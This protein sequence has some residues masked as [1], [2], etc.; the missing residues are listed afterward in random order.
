MPTPEL[1]NLITFRLA[2]L[3]AELNRQSMRLL[4]RA[5]KLN[6]PEWRVISIV[7]A[8]GELNG[9][10]I[11]RLAGLDPG[12]LSRTLAAL[13]SRGL[14]LTS[15]KQDD[16]RAVWVRLSE[17]GARLE[18]AVRPVMR[19]RH[20]RLM[21]ALSPDERAAIFPILDNL[22]KAIAAENALSGEEDPDTE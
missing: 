5:G 18:A 17:E 7:Y 16:R 14:V 8:G 15:R 21:A 13:E 12:L 19:A 1:E 4:R 6:I 10:Q 20:E 11:G 3:V 2:H 22:Y 9:R